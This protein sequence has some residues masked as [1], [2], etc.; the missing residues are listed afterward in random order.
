MNSLDDL[1]GRDFAP[2]QDIINVTLAPTPNTTTIIDT[3]T[4]CNC[5]SEWNSLSKPLTNSILESN[6]LRY[7]MNEVFKELFNTTSI[8]MDRNRDKCD[9]SLVWATLAFVFISMLITIGSVI[10]LFLNQISLISGTGKAMGE[11]TPNEES[12]LVGDLSSTVPTMRQPSRFPTFRNQYSP[13]SPSGLPSQQQQSLAAPKSVTNIPQVTR[14]PDSPSQM[15]DGAPSPLST[16]F[17]AGQPDSAKAT[18][19]PQ[20]TGVASNPGSNISQASRRRLVLP[21]PKG[22]SPITR[23]S[24]SGAMR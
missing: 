21:A 22:P 5:A 2:F 18:K 15:A 19:S 6:Q 1:V 10:Y 23:E 17:N 12:A 24:S 13:Q 4:V 8:V 7:K 20:E 3:K 11:R 14:A 9:L 16:V